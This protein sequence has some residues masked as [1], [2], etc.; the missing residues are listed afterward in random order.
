MSYRVVLHEYLIDADGRGWC[1]SEC[2]ANL[3][4]WEGELPEEYDWKVA[5]GVGR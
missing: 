2:R 3:P 1:R 4:H 5:L